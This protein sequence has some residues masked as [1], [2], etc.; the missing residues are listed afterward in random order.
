[1][2]AI[3][4]ARVSTKDQEEQGHS[5]PAQVAKLK[6]YAARHN[7]EI[8]REF[9][10][11]ESAG[12]KIRNRFEEVLAYLK[13]HKDVNV[14]LCQNVDRATRNFSDAV[15]I[16]NMRINE[17]LEVHFVQDGFVLNKN[18]SGAD[19]FMWEAKVFIAKQYINRLRDDSMRSMYYK[20]DS[21]ECVTQAPLGY[22]NAT[23]P[24]TG[25]KTVIFDKE[26]A[27]LVTQMFMEYSTGCYSIAELT[28]KITRWG[29]ASR[30]GH[31]LRPSH[32][33]KLLCN[34][35]YCGY[36][37]VKGK[38][39]HHKYERIIDEIIFR[40]CQSVRE[41]ANKKPFKYAKKP[42]IFRGILH[43]SECQCAY[44]SDIKK[45]KYIYLRP[46]K[47]KGP[48]DCYALREKDV[49][50][51]VSA[52]I[53]ELTIPEHFLERLKQELQDSV[54]SKKVLHEQSIKTIQTDY[55]L[56]QLKLDRLLDALIAGSI[57]QNEYDK[58]AYELKDRQRELNSHMNLHTD[59]D[60]DFVIS[61]STLLELCSK[62]YELF[63]SSEVERKRQLL[64]FLF[65][66]LTIKGGK[67][68]Y[69]LN[70]PFDQMLVLG[71]MKKWSG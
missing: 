39:Y 40:K 8:A 64:K 51:E 14:L 71:K 48:C 41:S 15:D 69:S 11:S 26:R 25:R 44:S 60:E 56:V 38:R 53:K 10:F 70:R 31:K 32:V 35:F 42:F 45:G 18:A 37:T 58:K 12:T 55:D 6:E 13:R 28:E 62:A 21:G 17:N 43:C 34:E 63:K 4:L 65:T 7:F 3:I 9:A 61:V 16:D 52:I 66:N 29:L 20:L 46:T 50:E 23:D 1:M 5:L 47:S 19:M 49:L 27:F 67:L 22:L 54:I 24:V 57:T 68:D 33:H 30:K 2:K 36:M 59:A